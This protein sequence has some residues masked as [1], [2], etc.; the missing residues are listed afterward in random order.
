MEKIIDR[1][2]YAD[3]WNIGYTY[4]SVSNLIKNK[5]LS[6]PITWLEED[7]SLY[8]A[9]PF[10]IEHGSKIYII[11]EELQRLYKRGKIKLIKDFDFT[12]KVNV[13]GLGPKNIHL[14]YPHIFIDNDVVYCIPETAGAKEVG[15]YQFGNESFS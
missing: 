14:S 10:V 12:S 3:K 15:L 11:Y 2:F 4:Q 6:G 8:A 7:T 13:K 9:D 5:N 1:I